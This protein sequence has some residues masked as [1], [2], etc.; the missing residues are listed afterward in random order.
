MLFFLIFHE[1]RECPAQKPV[2]DFLEDGQLVQYTFEKEVKSKL[3][4]MKI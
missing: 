2:N 4:L 1:T 3:G